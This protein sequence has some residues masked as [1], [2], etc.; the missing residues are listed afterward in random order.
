MQKERTENRCRKWSVSR[1]YDDD[2][3]DDD[4]END[5]DSWSSG[6]YYRAS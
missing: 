3:D 1:M 4:D 5:Y 6:R 2:D